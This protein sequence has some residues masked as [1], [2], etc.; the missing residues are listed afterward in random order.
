[1]FHVIQNSCIDY[2]SDFL[3]KKKADSTYK[4]LTYGI[5]N[6]LY[7][8]YIALSHLTFFHAATDWKWKESPCLWGFATFGIFL[9][10]CSENSSHFEVLRW[11]ER[12]YFLFFFLRDVLFYKK[13]KIPFKSKVFIGLCTEC[14]LWQWLQKSSLQGNFGTSTSLQQKSAT[15]PGLNV[16]NLVFHLLAALDF[17]KNSAGG[18]QHIL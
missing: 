4:E 16:C 12:T 11:H 8:F 18:N 7:K 3:N 17:A 2:Y 9:L 1:M 5:I 6:K 14:A 10:G 15:M 13:K